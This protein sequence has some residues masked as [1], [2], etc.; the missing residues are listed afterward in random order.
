MFSFDKR[1]HS[2]FCHVCIDD[3]KLNDVCENNMYVKFWQHIEINTKGK[4]CVAKFE[5][6]QSEETIVSS[7]GHRVSDI[8]R[9]G[10][11]S[12]AFK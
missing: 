7:E 11:I 2:C 6:M 4:M 8:V 9:E 3:T 5:E 10:N 12:I 1:K